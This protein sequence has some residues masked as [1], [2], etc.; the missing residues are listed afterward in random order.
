MLLGTGV[1]AKPAEAGF[2]KAGVVVVH[3]DGSV[4]TECVR[5]TKAQISGFKL[6]KL[7]LVRVHARPA[8]TSDAAICWI[9]GEGVEHDRSRRRASRPNGPTWD[10]FTQDKGASGPVASEVG[11]DDRTVTRGAVDY[12]A[13]GTF[14]ADDAVDAD[15]ARHLR[16]IRIAVTVVRR[17]L[18][19]CSLVVRARVRARVRCDPCGCE[20]AGRRRAQGGRLDRR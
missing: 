4:K 2:G 15:A 17:T 7:E 9:D 10:Y 1:I 20:R 12:W 13:F 5:L 11:P 16:L 6:L 19:V 8:S 3:G 14:P 18:V